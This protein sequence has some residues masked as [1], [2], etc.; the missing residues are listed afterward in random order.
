MSQYQVNSIAAAQ[1]PITHTFAYSI[2]LVHGHYVKQ[3]VASHFAYKTAEQAVAAG[4]K[5]AQMYKET[6]KFPALH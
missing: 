6:G 3:E 5:A 2:Q 1:S 4:E